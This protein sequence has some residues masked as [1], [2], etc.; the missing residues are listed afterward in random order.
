MRMMKDELWLIW[1]E[2]YSRRRYKVGVL[3]KE[4]NGYIFKY[5]NPELDAATEN[6]FKYFPGFEDTKKVYKNERLFMNIKTRLPNV[7]R[8]DYLEILNSYNLEK[9][10]D[11]FDIL[12][13]TR[14]RLITDDYEFV[15]AFDLNKIEFD[16]AGTRYCHDI[17]KCKKFLKINDK[18]LL[19][20]DSNNKFDSNAIKVIYSD[21]KNNYLLGFVPRYYTK[22]LLERLQKGVNYS[23]MIKSLNFDSLLSDENITASVKLIFDI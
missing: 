19:V 23:A 13:A 6:G 1:K 21:G 22:Q 18:L 10:S 4:V 9:D 12:R 2:P 7:A 17:N 16:I 8:P 11:D 14:G 15:P 5:E 20:I 3:L